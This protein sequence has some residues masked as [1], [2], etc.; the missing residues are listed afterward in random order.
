MRI[1]EIGAGTGKATVLFAA[2]GLGVV[3]LEPSAEM[4]RV[5]RAKCADYHGVEI[6]EAE[7]ERWQPPERFAAV[8]SVNAWH[9]I[10]A[11]Q[12]YENAAQALAPGATLAAIWNF[13]DWQRCPLRSALSAA[14]RRAVPDLG[15]EFPMHPDSEPTRLAGDWRAEIES[16]SAFGHPVTRSYR[17]TQPY[18]ASGYAALLATH[19]DHIL[20]QPGRRTELMTA[21]AA[22][23][24][25]A[26]GTLAMPF[27][28]YVC[29]ARRVP[30]RATRTE[31]APVDA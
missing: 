31:W 28:T 25:Q 2:R 29:L 11:E 13:P 18:T 10:D 16:T 22:T 9:W 6:V 7:F 14:Y 26:G 8:V 12:R 5:A 19:Q 27:V 23:I 1:V 24:D 21:I 17:W 30:I 20:L 4:A 15:P 3:G